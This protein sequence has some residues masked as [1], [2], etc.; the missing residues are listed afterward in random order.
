[1]TVRDPDK[2]E[3]T[4]HLVNQM[5]KRN[6]GAH[7]VRKAIREGTVEEGAKPTDVRYRLEIPGVDLL[8]VVDSRNNK[9]T[10]AFF[11]DDQGAEGGR[12]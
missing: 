9:I 6:I 3:G 10:S 5:R 2:L 1:M 4:S 12:I 7:E 11:D 8:V